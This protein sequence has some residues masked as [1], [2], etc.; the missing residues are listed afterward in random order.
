MLVDLRVS[1]VKRLLYSC[2]LLSTLVSVDTCRWLCCCL[3]E[4]EVALYLCLREWLV[5][6]VIS[7]L[8]DL[9]L[10]CLRIVVV[11]G[12]LFV[13]LIC[14]TPTTLRLG[15]TLGVGLVANFGGDTDMVSMDLFR[16]S[17]SDACALVELVGVLIVCASNYAL[18]EGSVL[19]HIVALM[20][21]SFMVAQFKLVDAYLCVQW[22]LVEML[23]CIDISY[24][25]YCVGLVGS[26]RGGYIWMRYDSTAWIVSWLLWVGIIITSYELVLGA[27][28]KRLASDSSV[29]CIADGCEIVRL[30]FLVDGLVRLV[31]ALVVW[32][33][34]FA[35]ADY[36]KRR[37]DAV[38]YLSTYYGNEADNNATEYYYFKIWVWIARMIAFTDRFDLLACFEA[39]LNCL[40]LWAV[41]FGLPG[42]ACAE[43]F[44]MVCCWFMNLGVVLS[45]LQIGGMI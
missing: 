25:C 30:M 22:E 5:Y 41:W 11:H 40:V 38:V 16:L 42:F 17:F 13:V 39:V 8:L 31:V 9:W 32:C 20:F 3:L 12:F 43:C 29:C 24:H 33:T 44:I 1:V 10:R 35:C 7:C 34:D 26:V 18:D 2:C 37:V 15:W 45:V 21:D 4:F 6:V 19:R 27:C 36:Y 23:I 14:F 28:D